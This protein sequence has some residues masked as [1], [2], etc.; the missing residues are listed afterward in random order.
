MLT[1][2]LRF[3][4][5]SLSIMICGHLSR[6]ELDAA[7]LANSVINVLGLSIDMGFSTASETLFCQT[8]GSKKRKL[9]GLLLQR[10]LLIMTMLFGI[11]ACIHI[12]IESILLLIGQNPIISSLTAEYITYILPGLFFDFMF[13][14]LARYLESQN[15]VRPMV[16]AACAGT[17]FT[18]FAQTFVLQWDL[19]LRASAGFLSISFGIMLLGEILYIFR[20]R[21]YV[22]TWGGCDLLGAMSEWGIFFR[23]G[24]PGILMIALEEWCLELNTFVAGTISEEILGAQAIAFQIQSIIYMIPLGISTA[25]NVR[26]GQGLGAFN[27]TAAKF[28][29]LT[30]LTSTVFI[31]FLTAAPVVL[32]RH[33]VSFIFTSDV[34]V[35]AK[36]SEILPMLFIFQFCEGLAG[37]SEAVLIACGRQV[38]GAVT[39]FFGYYALGLPLSFFFYLKCDLG[40]IGMWT[41]IA[42]G[43]FI[44]ALTYT[45]FALRTDWV[46]Q[47]RRAVKTV[48]QQSTAFAD[49]DIT[50]E[51]V[52]RIMSFSD[53]SEDRHRPT[54]T[55]RSCSHA[56]RFRV[57]LFILIGFVLLAS[58]V[59]RKTVAVPLWFERCVESLRL[60]ST[61]APFCSI[62]L[63]GVK[64]AAALP[65]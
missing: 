3:I 41:G 55:R 40:I 31:A 51:G 4:N 7:S 38:L 12:N 64:A 11:L 50:D 2:L 33:S 54:F 23:L 49:N 24:I 27:P 57:F 17:V 37:V 6:E 18:L 20:Y 32:F 60:N 63:A 46:Q 14:T 48:Q 16:L 34:E 13:M 35:A 47:S 42:I 25:V 39:I 56:V 15:L 53:G 10:A 58:I 61:L 44:T 43:F 59:H 22:E 65:A 62:D 29:Y 5:P 28:T 9:M 21:V 8:Y 45:F 52:V 26:V 30:A 1:H 36:A 19:G